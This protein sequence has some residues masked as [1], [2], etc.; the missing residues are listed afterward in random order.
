M[1]YFS[2]PTKFQD[3]YFKS[4]SFFLQRAKLQ[5]RIQDRDGDGTLTIGTLTRCL[6]ST[7][8][9]CTEELRALARF[10]VSS[11]RAL[12]SLRAQLTRQHM[13]EKGLA[14]AVRLLFL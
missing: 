14:T 1:F 12:F 3:S 7:L 11:M 4:L 2:V 10:T 5:F 6:D 9:L 8:T 13:A